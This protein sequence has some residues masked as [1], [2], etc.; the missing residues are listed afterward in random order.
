MTH[1]AV[2]YDPFRSGEIARVAPTTEAQREIIVSARMSDEANLGFNESSRLR[3]TGEVDTERLLKAVG[4]VTDRHDALHVVITGRGDEMCLLKDHRTPVETL[5]LRGLSAQERETRLESICDA[6]ATTP[7]DLQEGPLFW[8]KLALLD[9]NEHELMLFAHHVIGDGWSFAVIEEEI[10][11]LYNQPETR[12][13]LPDAPSF[14]DY[15]ELRTLEAADDVEFWVE[16]FDTLPPPLDLPLDKYREPVRRFSAG[17]IDTVIPDATVKQVNALAKQLHCSVVT[18]MMTAFTV[19]LHR[20]SG[21][22]DIVVGL[23]LAGQAQSGLGGLVGHCVQT[24]PIRSQMSQTTS[25]GELARDIRGKILDASEHSDFTFGTLV[26]KVAADYD[27]SRV[28]LVSVLFNI[29]QASDLYRFGDAECVV[30]G[31]P[32]VAEN[33]ELSLNVVPSSDGMLIET[34]YADSI[35]SEATVRSWLEMFL[36][37]LGSANGNPD[38][39]LSRLGIGDIGGT[40]DSLNATAR[41]YAV[42]DYLSLVAA[43]GAEADAVAVA[44]GATRLSYAALGE[45]S[46]QLANYLSSEHGVGPGDIV[47]LYLAREADLLTAMLAVSK[48]G[49]AYLPLDPGFPEARLA[50]ML[51]DTDARLVICNTD[52][53]ASMERARVD[54]RSDWPAIEAAASAEGFVSKASAAGVAYII[55]TSGSTGKPKGVE[56]SHR[57]LAN[58]LQTMAQQPGMA[59][60]DRLLA[61][62]T[63]S[64]DISMLELL[65]PL[66]VGGTVVVATQEESG[67]GHRLM[68]LIGEHDINVMQATPA[69]WRMLLGLGWEGKGELKVLCG[70]EALPPDLVGSLLPVVG[71]LW[72]M[73]GP[74]ETTIWSACKRIEDA[75]ELITIGKPIGNTQLYILNDAL[76]LQPVGVPGELYIGGDGVAEGYHKRAE[77]TA[78]R[79]IEHAEFGRI[80]RT[81]DRARVMGHGEVQHLG[82]LDDQIKL[83]GYRIELGEIEAALGAVEGVSQAAAVVRQLGPADERLVAFCICDNEKTLDASE[84][85]LALRK[86]LPDYMIPQHFIALDQLPVTPNNKLDRKALANRS[87]EIGASP[88]TVPSSDTGSMTALE[89]TI[90]EIFSEQLGGIAVGPDDD[91]FRL[92]GHSLTATWVIHAIEQRCR[93]RIGLGEFFTHPTAR[94]AAR[95]VE[96]QIGDS[97][98]TNTPVMD[99]AAPAGVSLPQALDP[100]APVDLSP[101]QHR[102]WLVDQIFPDATFHNLPSSF[103][104]RG[105]LDVDALKASFR[106]LVARQPVLRTRFHENGV[107]VMQIIG[108][109]DAAPMLELVDVSAEADPAAAVLEWV[110]QQVATPFNLENDYLYRC[111][112]SRLG[113]DD[114]AIFFMPHHIVF[115]GW[116]FDVF[117]RELNALY[118]A[119][120]S[121]EKPSLPVH[122]YEYRD[123]CHWKREQVTSE[124]G[125]ALVERW[126]ERLAPLPEM[127]ELPRDFIPDPDVDPAKVN[128]LP[129]RLEPDDVAAI[130]SACEQQGVTLFMLFLAAYAFTLARWSANEELVIGTPIAGRD[131]PGSKDLLG[132]FVNALPLKINVGNHASVGDYLAAVRQVCMDAFGDPDVPID[133]LV[134][135]FRLNQHLDKNPIFQVL[136]AYEDA[137]ERTV[138]LG[139]IQFERMNPGEDSVETDL[140]F[141]VLDLASGLIGGFQYRRAYF[142]QRHMEGFRDTFLDAMRTM[143]TNPSMSLRDLCKPAANDLD[144][145]RELNATAR[146]Y[147]QG[148]YL[149]LVAASG[150]SADAVAVA[151]G[152]TRLSYASLGERSDQLA[153][154]LSSEHGVGPGDIVGLYLA[155][156][157]DLLTAMLAVSKTGAA[158]LPLDPGF[159][160][161][162]LAFMLE[163]TDA[164]LVICNT[165]LPASMERARVDLRSDWPAIEAA[166]SAEGFVSKASAAGVAYIIYT[167]GSTGKPKGVEV[168]HRALANFLQT[169]AQQPG[170]AAGDRLLAVTT[171][172]FDISML[173]LLLPLTVGG[174]VVVATQEESGDGHRL[175]ELIGEHDINVMQATPATWRMLLGLGWEG[176][177]ELKVL[178]GGEALPPDLVGSLLP[179]VGEL[180]NMYGPTETTIW[181]ACKRIEDAGELITIGKPIGNTQLY[182]LNDALQLQP[183]GVPGELYIGGDGVAEGYHKRAELTAERFIEHAE[184]GRIYRTG[185]RARVMGH[186]E[187]QHLG[188]L[189]DQIK[190]RGYRIELGEIEAALGAVEGV[191]QAAAR[192][193]EVGQGDARLIGYFVLDP[194]SSASIASIRGALRR[195][196]PNYMVPTNLVEL[197]ALPLT[198]NGKVDRKSL[199]SLESL[200]A[201]ADQKA[202]LESEEQKQMASIWAELIGVSNIGPDDNFFQLGGHSLLVIKAIK[203]AAEKFETP[204]RP[205]ILIMDNLR[206]V[207]RCA[208]ALLSGD[209]SSGQA[210]QASAEAGDGEVK[211]DSGLFGTMRKKGG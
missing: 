141:W 86:R 122:E 33:F 41:D 10:V 208:G 72:N 54:L 180:W 93:V 22:S 98:V 156:E 153:N 184:F 99:S 79:F 12:A 159:P 36:Q 161:A 173:E 144:C 29:D 207:T 13:E 197:D 28:P 163:D 107:D 209:N 204:L 210:A 206:E 113:E 130:R 177:G 193:I 127:L 160:E 45:R 56:V 151:S 179:V 205:K 101:S 94:G 120:V 95:L 81:G 174:T 42:S 8:V 58:F 112:L 110:K 65:L 103:R 92:G 102:M 171:L 31:V 189:D 82:R 40:Y 23:P 201:A 202:P 131:V 27:R 162:R 166:A 37:L 61:V 16:Q 155:R 137:R 9:A 104:L 114:H 7:I 124:T 84:I 157:A 203:I 167:S 96:E 87:D 20:L 115:D 11:E 143:A 26:Q 69:T 196:L 150:A 125:Q 190:L 186:G 30:G 123:Y 140:E 35:Y 195:R 4:D 134:R 60:G 194:D 2:D 46:D 88:S 14:V 18:V 47:G 64:F 158:Y 51:E 172:S 43:S 182:I 175:M 77:L 68:E 168:S 90:V 148:D 83:R 6:F 117:Y 121:G 85:R 136:F 5:D 67:D 48:T 132:L 39:S 24:L 109:I 17:R 191:S 139:D 154:Y 183:V 129:I 116:S 170:M 49:A 126:R 111:R 147:A 187:V 97:G 178:C 80:Y 62:T 50:F 133:E 145:Y 19:L 25:F 108:D 176:K 106:D 185:D 169:M 198:P 200:S 15:A 32:R 181:S 152:A 38:E 135:E 118:R 142:E 105:S 75:G 149:S 44:S 164:R 57:A 52:L 100:E 128:A 199:P 55:Y 91:F 165:D 3:I 73:Y 70:G 119:R 211:D 1:K 138:Q 146:E 63:L 192:I 53:P 188:R 66:T 34:M 74:T 76:Q 21:N 89:M 59:A 71:E 78:E